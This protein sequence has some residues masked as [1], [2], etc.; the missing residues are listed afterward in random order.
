MTVQNTIV[1][2]VYVGNGSTTIFPFTFE[3]NKA[4]HIQAFV[5]DA[6]GNISSTTNFKVDLE[7]KNLTYPNTGEPLAKGDKLIILRQLPLQQLLNL[8]NQGPFYAEDIEETFD[9]VVMMLQQMTER[10]GR[11]LAVSVD[12]DAENSF[13]T[14][15]PLEAGKTF[16][17]KDDGTGFE[18][19]EDPG[20]VIDGAK[21]LLKQTMEQAELAKEQADASSQSAF[22][23]QNAAKEVKEIYND[24]N[25]TPLSDLLGS[26][27]TKLKRW[28]SIFANK[29]F[30]SNLPIVYNNV[31]E[32]KADTMLWEGMNTKTL[33]YYAPNDGG[34]ASY[35]IRGKLESDVDDG[36]S[37][38]ELANGLVAEL[39]IENGIVNVKQFGAVGN[40]VT[41]D[42][43]VLQRSFDSLNEVYIPKGE[44]IYSDIL[45]IKNDSFGDGKESILFNLS[46]PDSAAIH[47]ESNASVKNL[48][49]KITPTTRAGDAT[50]TSPLVILKDKENIIIDDVEC[51]GGN[52]TGIFCYGGKNITI[53]NVYVHDTLADGIHVTNGSENVIVENCHVK[54]SG[55]DGI[56]FISYTSDGKRV[57][58]CKAIH[59]TVEG[60]KA[61]GITNGGSEDIVISN[62]YITD[63]NNNGILVHGTMGGWSFYTA[64]NTVISNNVCINNIQLAKEA[65]SYIGLYAE[66]VLQEADDTSETNKNTIIAGNTISSFYNCLGIFRSGDVIITNNT[67]N[68]GMAFHI[69]TSGAIN[70]VCENVIINNNVFKI[71]APLVNWSTIDRIK[72]A[73]IKDN[74]FVITDTSNHSIQYNDINGGEFSGNRLQ[75]GDSTS[76]FLIQGG[77]EYT[78]G[79]NYPLPTTFEFNDANPDAENGE[80]NIV[81]IGGRYGITLPV[82]DVSNHHP[83][84]GTM[85]LNNDKTKLKIKV[86]ATAEGTTWK[87]VTLSDG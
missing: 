7:Q 25:F 60:T 43:I 40:G 57:K 22:N 63:C 15:I 28:G 45:T 54:N 39:M 13:N 71:G 5:K 78:L 80:Y 47:I 10:I 50:I 84:I 35:L 42:T 59:N 79:Y 12:I 14:I 37:I 33:G 16:R 58:N 23:A 36:G 67:F 62:N 11:S 83:A 4:E 9:E 41:D 29:V 64:K 74:I 49:I 27:G 20:K 51:E 6:L 65:T 82:W 1:K 46:N 21:A 38:Q 77:K 18:V 44:Y 30:A 66:I 8:L 17:V 26:L 69:T 73:V 2:N 75:R 85:S 52:G 34:G 56:A 81:S 55:D 86:G 53:H 48:K 76:Y 24:G 61:R 70:K 19:T 87:Y 72:E 31:E 3:C 68:G 32:M